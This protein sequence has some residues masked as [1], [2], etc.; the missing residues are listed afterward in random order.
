MYVEQQTN[1]YNLRDSRKN[2]SRLYSAALKGP[3]KLLILYHMLMQ[4]L[5]LLL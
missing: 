4:L 5:L 1:L 3:L 2:E